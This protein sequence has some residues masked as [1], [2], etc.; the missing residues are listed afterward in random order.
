MCA[1]NNRIFTLPI[2]AF[3]L[4]SRSVNGLGLVHCVPDASASFRLC[5]FPC[6]LGNRSAIEAACC[7]VKG[8]E[9]QIK[10]QKAR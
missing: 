3:R 1:M 6:M 5:Y 7:N 9:A 2:T 10:M 4:R 8:V